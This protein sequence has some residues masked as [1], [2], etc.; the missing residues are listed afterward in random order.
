[1][2]AQG[3]LDRETVEGFGREWATFRQGEDLTA[4]E[5]AKFLTTTSAFFRGLH[6]P[7]MR[8][9]STSVAAAAV[10]RFWSRRV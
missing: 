6:C 7:A 4:A 9:A 5:R 10:G 1:M 3:N 2:A 8:S